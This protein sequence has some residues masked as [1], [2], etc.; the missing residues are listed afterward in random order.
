M[1]LYLCDKWINL[2]WKAKNRK[3]QGKNSKYTW[4]IVI[5]EIVIWE[6]VHFGSCSLRKGLWESTS[7]LDQK[8][9]VKKRSWGYKRTGSTVLQTWLRNQAVYRW[10]D[11]VKEMEEAA[12]CRQLSIIP[13]QKQQNQMILSTETPLISE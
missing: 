9:Q 8:L 3:L 13:L 7:Y 2:E 1:C 10:K 5:W 11:L 4:E 12:R 6:N